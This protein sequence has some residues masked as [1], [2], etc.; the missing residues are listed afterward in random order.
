M[1][2]CHIDLCMLNML[3]IVV[4]GVMFSSSV[5]FSVPDSC[6]PWANS[7]AA[8]SGAGK[9]CQSLQSGLVSTGNVLIWG[10]KWSFGNFWLMSLESGLN[11][12]SSAR[13]ISRI[14][15]NFHGP[16]R[17]SELYGYTEMMSL[18]VQRA[19]QRYNKMQPTKA[20]Q[21]IPSVLSYVQCPGLSSRNEAASLLFPVCVLWEGD[22][23]QWGQFL[24]LIFQLNA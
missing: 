8:G 5:M 13:R 9:Q 18:C 1:S 15:A 14:I 11:C 17:A 23:V 16:C 22:A 4:A 7:N 19:E 12:S 3:E 10:Q 6:K 2:R 21:A 24:C 20:G